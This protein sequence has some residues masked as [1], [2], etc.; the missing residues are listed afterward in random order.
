MSGV[1]LVV[2]GAWAA[3]VPFFGPYINLAYTPA[4]NDAWHWTADRGW[5]SVAPGAA[6]FLG[7]LLLVFS[8]SRVVTSLGGWLAAAGGAWLIVGPPLANTLNLNLGVPDP[9]SSTGVQ[10]L[11]ALLFFY[12]IGAAI[13]LLAGLALGRLSIRSLRD[14]Q[15]AQ[16]RYEEV[17]PENDEVV[18]RREDAVTRRGDV[19]GP[20]EDVAARHGHSD[21]AMPSS[22]YA[23]PT[24]AQ[25]APQPPPQG[26]VDR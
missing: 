19:A 13:V 21:E 11:T 3:L 5:L 10:A 8:A 12:A 23:E 4:P 1:L 16:R 22:N 24:Y 2:A 26:S 20:R 6:A 15:A 14:V 18:G 7:G 9:T 17:P 25:G